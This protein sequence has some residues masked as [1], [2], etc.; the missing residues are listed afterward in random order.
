MYWRS[1]RN[2]PELWLTVLLQHELA[3]EAMEHDEER[4]VRRS[5]LLSGLLHLFKF[6]RCMSPPSIDLAKDDTFADKLLLQPCQCL[7]VAP[8]SH[9]WHFKCIR[10]LLM[11][12]HY[13][14]FICPNCR[15]AADLEAE[16]EDPEDWEQLEE[17]LEDP[18]KPEESRSKEPRLEPPAPVEASRNSVERI[19]TSLERARATAAE[20]ARTSIERSR[21]RT[22]PP[23]TTISTPLGEAPEVTMSNSVDDSAASEQAPSGGGAS[24]PST[25]GSIR[26]S[27]ELSHATS[28]PVRINGRRTPSP[29]SGGPT[30]AQHEGPITPRNDAGP[31]VFDGSGAR[32]GTTPNGGAR[33]SLNGVVDMDVED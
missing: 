28:D 2:D 26:P 32:I 5:E 25:M 16:V 17:E 7:F 33:Q 12:P 4:R 30:G 10:S 11:S 22:H 27:H 1:S 14:I 31:W 21:S 29:G 18:G 3:Q 19:R 9:T 8:C 24:T 23:G 13:P 20:R 6:D 15:A